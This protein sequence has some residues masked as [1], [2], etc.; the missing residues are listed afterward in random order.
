[1]NAVSSLVWSFLFG[2]LLHPALGADNEDLAAR[3]KY[4]STEIRELVDQERWT[5]EVAP[6]TIVIESK[7]N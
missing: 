3:V 2:V 5:V 4:H 7:F 1:M 6:T